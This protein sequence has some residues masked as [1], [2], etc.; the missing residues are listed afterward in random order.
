MSKIA[1]MMS[2]NEVKALMPSHFGK[3]VKGGVNHG[4][5]HGLPYI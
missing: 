3:A 1:A 2:E 4:S 5:E